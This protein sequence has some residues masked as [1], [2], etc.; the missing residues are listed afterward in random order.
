M[1]AFK[2]PP[3]FKLFDFEA[4]LVG[5]FLGGPFSGGILMAINYCRMGQKYCALAT[6]ISGTLL[7]GLS[8]MLGNLNST[9][10]MYTTLS[11]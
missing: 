2:V 7:T 8:C 9:L 10:E 4:I 5:A 3:R 1:A 6:A 11:L